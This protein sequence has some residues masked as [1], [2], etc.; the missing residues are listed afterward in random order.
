LPNLEII[1]GWQYLPEVE[2]IE[3]AKINDL[4]IDNIKLQ[5]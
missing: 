4:T 2:A 1:K 3:M 5:I